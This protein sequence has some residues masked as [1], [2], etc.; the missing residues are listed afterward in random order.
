[1]NEDEVFRK[2][3]KSQLEILRDDLSRRLANIE[4]II[5]YVEL[6]GKVRNLND[7]LDTLKKETDNK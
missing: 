2:L 7:R 5:E 4:S 6:W 1:V 3:S